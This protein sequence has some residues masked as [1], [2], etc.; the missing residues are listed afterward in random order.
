MAKLKLIILGMLVLVVMT[1]FYFSND[2]VKIYRDLGN[3]LES[4]EKIDFN[5]LISQVKKEIVIPPPLYQGGKENQVILTKA[6]IVAQTNIQRYNN[7]QLPPL[8]ENV[9]LDEAAKAKAEDMFQ[10]QYFEHISPSGVGPGDLATRF[11][12]EYILEG[13]NLI[14]GNFASEKELVQ[15][16]MDS[17]GHRA[18]I[19]HNRYTEIGVAIVKGIYNGESVWIGVQEFGL[20]LSNCPKLSV[21][22]K[23]AIDTNKVQLDQL[24]KEIDAKKVELENA[25]PKPKEYRQLVDGYDEL[26]SQ[27]NAL[28]Q[29][30]KNLISQYN[31][32]V[33]AFN[34][35]VEDN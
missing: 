33:S 8:I 24:S 14:L 28:N 34:K 19:L 27:Y 16:W 18:N 32:Q 11:G 29:E 35:C 9:K 13:E 22:L 25:N 20:P 7:G 30:T 26:V 15:A 5:N 3:N 12:Y 10:K 23:S 17:P 31:I 6:K 2:I 1:G 4:F 21:S